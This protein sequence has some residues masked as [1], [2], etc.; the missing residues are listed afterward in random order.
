MKFVAAILLA[1]V[2]AKNIPKRPT[3]QS[4]LTPAEKREFL[5]FTASEGKSYKTSQEFN[6][7]AENWKKTDEYL[8][9]R[10]GDGKG[11]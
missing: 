1:A 8:K 2:T 11:P 10:K 7:R 4:S 9:I 6:E 5:S 3:T